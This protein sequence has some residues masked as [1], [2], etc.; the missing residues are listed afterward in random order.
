MDSDRFLLL[1][2]DINKLMTAV[3]GIKSIEPEI[4][5]DS[6]LREINIE[7][8]PKATKETV[9]QNVSEKS[10]SIKKVNDVRTFQRTLIHPLSSCLTRERVEIP[11]VLIRAC[12]YEGRHH[13]SVQQF[14]S[15]DRVQRL[16]HQN[17]LL[18]LSCVKLNSYFGGRGSREAGV[19]PPPTIHIFESKL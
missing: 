5:S 3:C 12:Q 19:G 17:C 1:L 7:Q 16:L 4:C 13:F 2:K 10:K 14:T 8:F 11:Q 18:R 9:K 15:N 6:Y